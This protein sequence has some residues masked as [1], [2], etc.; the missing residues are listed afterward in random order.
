M[1]NR[2]KFYRIIWKSMGTY[3]LKIWPISVL[4]NSV[5]NPSMTPIYKSTPLV[6]FF[7]LCKIEFLYFLEKLK[8]DFTLIWKIWT[9]IIW[10]HVMPKF[11]NMRVT[12]LKGL[13]TYTRSAATKISK[14]WRRR[15]NAKN[16]MSILL[17]GWRCQI[18]TSQGQIAWPSW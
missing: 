2:S 4:N 6:M 5:L 13:D 3:N 7:K 12:I 14:K 8:V 16:L 9:F 18:W 1:S 17:S 10:K 11:L 15:E